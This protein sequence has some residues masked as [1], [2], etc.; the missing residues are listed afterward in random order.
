MISISLWEMLFFAGSFFFLAWPLLILS[1]LN[2]RRRSRFPETFITIWVF[3]AVVRFFLIF[4]PVGFLE[5][6]P[7]PLYSI[8]FLLVGITLVGIYLYRLRARKRKL[9][10][11]GDE[12]QSPKDLLDLTPSEF[13]EMVVELYRS[14]GHR[15]MRTGQIGDHG[16]DVIIEAKN[17]EKWIAQC[18]RWRGSVGEPIIR[19]F[20]GTMHHEKA[21]KG[22]LITT[23]TFTTQAREWARG[24]PIFFYDGEEFLEAWRRSKDS[25]NI[26]KESLS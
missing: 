8:L 6:F 23:G 12:A 4:S 20:Y 15:A 9:H 14:F 1:P 2:W 3:V 26:A 16:V 13:E 11:T 17:G 5:V 22:A 24:K 10:Q 7:E 21:A 19:D 18:K 25:G